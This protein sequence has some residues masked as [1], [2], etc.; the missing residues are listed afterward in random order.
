MIESYIEDGAQKA[1]ENI[2]GKSITDPCLGWK[3]T[4]KLILDLAEML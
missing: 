1:E 3:K 2:Y 4:E